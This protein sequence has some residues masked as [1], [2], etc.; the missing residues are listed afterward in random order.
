MNNHDLKLSVVVP[1]Y[2]EAQN[3]PLIVSRFR[4]I[5]QDRRNVEVI[6]VNNG[7][8]DNSADVLDDQMRIIN[9]P[10]FKVVD[11]KVNKGYGFGILSGLR[12]ATGDILAWTHADMQTDPK[13]VIRAYDIL[14]NDPSKNIFVKGK[15]KNRRLSEAFFTWC[16]QVICTVVLKTPLSDINA[17]PKVFHRRFYDSFLT[18]GAPDDFSLDLY[19]LY[20]AKK[21]C[22]IQEIDVIF[23]KR[24]HG[25]A[26]GGGSFKT[27]MKLIRRTLAYIFDLK[28]RLTS[29]EKMT[30]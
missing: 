18:A 19:A 30:S 21:K 8:R 2:N 27:R 23:E 24:M 29:S 11:V 26:K 6:L 16:M 9:D 7:S 28:S 13:D 4:E 3:I 15:R 14:N 5:I 10:R 1:C 17:Q 12:S 25:E 22:H 20:W